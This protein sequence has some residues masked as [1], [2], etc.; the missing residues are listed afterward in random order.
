MEKKA[1]TRGPM[2][3]GK[4]TLPND[5]MMRYV[6][7]LYGPVGRSYA[8]HKRLVWSVVI[9]VLAALLLWWPGWAYRWDW[10]GL[11]AHYSPPKNKAGERD[12]FPAKTAWDW[13]QLLVI[14]VA[15]AVVGILVNRADKRRDQAIAE[16][17]Q[18][19][20][21]LE[22]YFTTMTTLLLDKKLRESDEKDESGVRAVARAQTL[23]TLRKLSGERK[24]F[25]LRFLYESD[26]SCNNKGKNTSIVDLSGATLSGATLNKAFLVEAALG[27]TDLSKATLA[28]AFLTK[29]VLSG[30][31]LTGA[32]LSKADLVEADLVEA[33]LVGADLSGA[34][35]TGADLSGADL[36]GADLSGANLSGADLS[37]ADLSGANLSGANLNKV[38]GVS[39]ED[40]EHQ[41]K[42]LE[43]ATMPNG[44]KHA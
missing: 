9:I 7:R 34:F 37:G 35:L 44:S 31:F 42:S 22:T 19:E 41:A 39:V 30:A 28:E 13:L 43:G 26:L 24:G 38:E 36:S 2:S 1:A 17:R 27:G 18:Q 21:A 8:M 4:V 11:G 33:D 12:Y 23:T 40:L 25:V 14:P 20:V 6:K 16:D 3:G 32:D 29:A 10:T 5:V 15:L